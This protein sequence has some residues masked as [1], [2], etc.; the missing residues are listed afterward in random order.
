MIRW[1]STTTSAS[2]INCSGHPQALARATRG[3]LKE[4]W[5]KLGKS[6][7][8]GRMT[9]GHA[10]APRASLAAL[11][12]PGKRALGTELLLSSIARANPLSRAATFQNLGHVLSRLLRLTILPSSFSVSL[13]TLRRRKVERREQ[14]A[15][16]CTDRR[17]SAAW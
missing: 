4:R 17:S 7:L 3:V 10:F 9:A 6:S 8:S 14:V 2:R 11:G 15:R 1:D 16:Y 13:A 12:R 5:G